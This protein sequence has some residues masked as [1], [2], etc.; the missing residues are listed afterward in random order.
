MAKIEIVNGKSEG[1]TVELNGSTITFGNRRSATI[2]LKDTWISFNHAQITVEGGRFYIADQRS[3]MGT[4]VNGKKIDRTPVALKSGDLIALGKTECRFHDDS[5]A[6][7]AAPAPAAKPAA[8]PPPPPAEASPFTPIAAPAVNNEQL[9]KLEAERDAARSEANGL[10]AAVVERERLVATLQAKVRGFE[11]GTKHVTQAF[12]SELM[13]GAETTIASLRGEVDRW[14][15]AYEDLLAKAR[16]GG[17]GEA[18]Q[19]EVERWKKAY[20]DVVTKAKA[21]VEEL[22]RRN[23]EL[24]E[25]GSKPAGDPE[26]ASKLIETA[27]KL[28]DAKSAADDADK[29]ASDA[30]RELGQARVKLDDALTE[31]SKLKSKL[32]EPSAADKEVK[33]L[34]EEIKALEAALAARP[35]QEEPDAF[36]GDVP[37][38]DDPRVAELE[39]RA[40]TAEARSKELESRAQKSDARAKELEA[41]AKDLEAKL[42]DAQAAAAAAP[43]ASAKPAGPD[44]AKVAELEGKLATIT[45]ERDEAKKQLEAVRADIE[46]LNNDMLAQEEELRGEITRLEQELETK[47]G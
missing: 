22:T 13:G 43:K 30:E 35:A 9:K 34:K 11:E 29:R 33:K 20:E 21:K 2:E 44:P 25:T 3:K 36:G 16:A 23:R 14:K 18:V 41:K 19:G 7:A 10:R 38:P 8:A 42:K 6:P 26:A 17:I 4:F 46:S 27:R 31:V 15:K 40:E 47:Q 5:A 12:K 24:E 45:K 39:V 37:P 1:K 32:G 28:A